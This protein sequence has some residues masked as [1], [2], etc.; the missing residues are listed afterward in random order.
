MRGGSD[1]AAG[2]LSRFLDAGLPHYADHHNHPDA[3]CTS[4]LSPYL[5]FGHIS[6]HQ[7]FAALMTRER[8]TTRRL[9]KRGGGAREGWWGVSASA[10]AFLDQLVVWRE[11][12]YNG[13]EWT[14]GFSRYA[15]VPDWAK[16][17]LAAHASD[18]RPHRY[19]FATL[20]AAATH[21]EVW[22]A[23]QRQLKAE[24]WFHGYLRMLWGKKILE[25]SP[26]PEA[27]LDRMAR[28]MD[29]Y[30]LDGRDPNSYAGYTWV[31]GRYD[32]PWP[33]RPIFGT[34]R[35]MT[36]ASARRKLRMK[37]FLLKYGIEGRSRGV[38]KSC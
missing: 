5:H 12:A 4:R 1:A 19:G 25:W 3:N 18:R 32:R 16:H 8:W 31:L 14:P 13:C 38:V 9:A 24:G 17:T 21:D 28:L 29:R 37:E 30:S 6:V 34:V 20:D 27:A 22:N 10:E 33:E 23:A 2:T 15:S 36:S 7:V 11:L 35:T 26:G